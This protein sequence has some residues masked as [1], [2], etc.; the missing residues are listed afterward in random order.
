M[1][2][3]RESLKNEGITTDVEEVEVPIRIA[4]A[5]LQRGLQVLRVQGTFDDTVPLRADPSIKIN[6][7]LRPRV[8]SASGGLADLVAEDAAGQDET[9]H[10]RRLSPL[11][12]WGRITIACMNFRRDKGLTNLAFDTAALQA[13]FRDA[14]IVILSTPGYFRTDKFSGLARVEGIVLTAL[15]KY[16]ATYYER[17]RKEWETKH[18][19]LEP[20]TEADGNLAFGKYIVK[21]STEK[22]G[23]AERL[24]ALVNEAKKLYERPLGAADGM[25]TAYIPNHLYQPLLCGWDELDNI[26]PT[27]LEPSETDF[28]ADL[29]KH[30]QAHPELLQGRELFLLR[31]QVTYGIVFYDETGSG[32]YPDFLLWLV[33]TDGAQTLVFIDPHGIGREPLTG[34]KIQLHARLRDKIAPSLRAQHPDIDLRLDAFILAPT[35]ASDRSIP[36]VQDNSP[37]ALAAN[38]ILFQKDARYIEKLFAALGR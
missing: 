35:H 32:F 18:L 23:V 36:I 31:N 15:T 34:A 27:G 13:V 14:A 7:D 10:L 2:K 1:A 4:D 25:P 8:E 6:L 30:L 3:F 9:P 19:R 17:R 38:H 20:L 37:E 28:I 21:V 12:D 24:T 29:R 22:P 33:T 16:I 11:L 26:K 5:F